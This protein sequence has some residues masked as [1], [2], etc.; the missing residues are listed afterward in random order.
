[1]AIEIA[2]GDKA[3]RTRAVF[4]AGASGDFYTGMGW[5]VGLL[6]TVF[7]SAPI[8]WFLMGADILPLTRDQIL[9]YGIAIAWWLNPFSLGPLGYIFSN[10]RV[11]RRRTALALFVWVVVNLLVSIAIVS[12]AARIIIVDGLIGLVYVLL[13]LLL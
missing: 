3:K 11:W 2:D 1:M 13:V 12:E 7:V 5:V 10:V 9:S 8:I 4:A 6:I